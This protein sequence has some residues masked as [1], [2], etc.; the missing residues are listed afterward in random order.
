MKINIRRALKEDCPRLLELITELAVYEKAP[1]DVTVTLA[2]KK[3][4]PFMVLHYTISA[5]PPGKDKP[6]TSKTLL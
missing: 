3:M 2:Q 1:D 6:C 4:E 5:T